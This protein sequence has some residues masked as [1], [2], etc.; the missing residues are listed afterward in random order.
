MELVLKN[1]EIAEH[2]LPS[3]P[4]KQR[5]EIEKKM[6]NALATRS[7]RKIGMSMHG[8]WRCERI[9]MDFNGQ[10]QGELCV[11][12]LSDATIS[13]DDLTGYNQMMNLVQQGFLSQFSILTSSTSNAEFDRLV[14]YPSFTVF[15]ERV[16]GTQVQ[17]IVKTIEHAPIALTL[18]KFPRTLGKLDLTNSL[19]LL[20]R[21]AN[22]LYRFLLIPPPVC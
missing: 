20:T 4:Q 7:F 19:V 9:E 16:I 1:L 18:S 8:S 5:V 11:V 12:P 6:Q 3:L 14:G 13:P 21:L 2:K 22:R 15:E 10:K 17:V